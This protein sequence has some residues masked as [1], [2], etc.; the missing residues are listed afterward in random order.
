MGAERDTR[1]TVVAAG[2]AAALLAVVGD[3]RV[4]VQ[5]GPG[6]AALA[7]GD[8]PVAAVGPPV[9]APVGG[10]VQ[11]AA[12]VVLAGRVS[13]ALE[14]GNAGRAQPGDA[15]EKSCE[16]ELHGVRRGKVEGQEETGV[17]QGCTWKEQ[18]VVVAKGW[19]NVGIV[20]GVWLWEDYVGSRK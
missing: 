2:H 5:R 1:R 9:G 6:D 8:G 15:E 12:D 3:A 20:R 4:L 13:D 14:V 19:R 7:R 16:V 18:R 17:L 10:A 11:G